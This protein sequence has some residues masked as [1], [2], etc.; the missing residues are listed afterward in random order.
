MS[1]PRPRSPGF[2]THRRPGAT[3]ARIWNKPD[4]AG[5]RH[6]RAG[7]AAALPQM[8]GAQM[9]RI[10]R[11]NTATRVTNWVFTTLTRLGIGASYRHLLTV[12]GRKTGQLHTTPVDVMVTSGQ[13]WLVAGYGPA[14]WVRNARAAG[15]V[16]LSRGGH[17]RRYA[18]A[19][20]APGEAIPVLRKYMTDVRVTRP[21][22]DATPASPDS[23]IEAELARHPVL[24]I[25][26]KP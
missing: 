26:P 3:C 14:N 20:P 24:Q 7:A 15:E 19:E 5:P 11:Q 13:R 22:F 8:T 2:A 16:T 10:Y 1:A 23:Q 18:I 21:Y 9:A 6:C 25:I 17:Q 4:G 12:R